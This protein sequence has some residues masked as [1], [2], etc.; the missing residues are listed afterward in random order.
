MK[1]PQSNIEKNDKEFAHPGFSLLGDEGESLPP[2]KNLLIP[3]STWKNPP[4]QRQFPLV[5][6]PLK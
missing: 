1:E 4:T 6:L 2:V 3:H 5:P